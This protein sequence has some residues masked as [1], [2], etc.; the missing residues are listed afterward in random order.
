MNARDDRF[1]LMGVVLTAGTLV[2]S[3]PAFGQSISDSVDSVSG[4]GTAFGGV[5][6]TRQETPSGSDNNTRPRLGISGDIGG[7]MS[8]G[9]N[10]LDLR[11]GGTLETRRSLPS[12][13]QTDSTSITGASRYQ[14]DNPGGRL[15]FNLGHSIESVRND[16]GFVL[17]S[18]DYDTRNTLSAGA[19]LMFYPGD[20]TSLRFSAE[21]G[22]SFGGGALNDSESRTVA[23]E[24]TRRLS[25]QSLGTLVARRSWSENRGLDTTIDNAELGYQ[26]ELE[27]GSFSMAAGGSWS[28]TEFPGQQATNESEAVTGHVSR[29]WATRD[30]STNIRYNRRLSDSATDLS[31]NLPA[32]LAFLPDTVRLRDLVVS[33][34]LLV[35]H[36]TTRLCQICQVWLIAEGAVLQS[37]LTD[38]KTHEYR[39][40]MSLDVDLTRLHELRV[41]Y[42][43]QGDAGEDSGD[44]VQQ[45]HRLDIALTR[46]LAENTRLGV[47]LNQAWV[48][49]DEQNR[50]QEQY[51][52]RIFLTRDF[53]LLARR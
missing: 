13:D 52:L 43:W 2:L 38:T 36:S 51:G 50:D 35:S 12:G 6:H 33:D 25:E 41:A 45:T 4:S 3:S 14:Y 29:T 26:R 17:N 22:E 31:L 19:G 18:G 44:L 9:A 20:L 53:S 7:S 49:R 15:D 10:S 5:V 46:R 8:S 48:R 11:Y 28:E 23:S 47:E 1:K 30:T 37:E 24:V 21:A 32:E 16:T 34:S 27:N 42:S 39:T 40:T